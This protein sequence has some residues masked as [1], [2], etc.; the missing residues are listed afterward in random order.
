M[1][2]VSVLMPAYNGERYLREA[3]DSVL[4]QTFSDFELVIVDD[5]SSDQTF[6]I[7]QSYAAKTIASGLSET[8]TTLAL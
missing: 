5:R 7:A 6:S 2:E 4:A 8:T 1:P 3:I